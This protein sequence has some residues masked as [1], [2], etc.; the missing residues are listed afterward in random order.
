MERFRR[1]CIWPGCIKRLHPLVSRAR[2]V[3]SPLQEG[4]LE[5][6]TQEKDGLKEPEENWR[7]K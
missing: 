4:P 2:S 1:E 7:R 6:L 3:M 5:K